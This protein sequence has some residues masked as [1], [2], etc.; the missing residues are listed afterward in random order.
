MVT[1]H[2]T[3]YHHRTNYRIC[4]QRGGY[5]GERE[6]PQLYNGGIHTGNATVSWSSAGALR[7][8]SQQEQSKTFEKPG[9]AM[10]AVLSIKNPS[11]QT[12][13][14][15]LDL[16]WHLSAGRVPF[17]FLHLLHCQFNFTNWNWEL[18]SSS[19]SAFIR[20]ENGVQRTAAPSSE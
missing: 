6:R 7:T 8:R 3:V 2:F 20:P 13:F 11:L 12:I 5:N 18:E 4:P 9:R 10:A 15:S 19:S 17:T 1:S 14:S 16:I